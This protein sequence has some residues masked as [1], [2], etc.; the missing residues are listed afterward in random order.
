MTD[1][2]LFACGTSTSWTRNAARAEDFEIAGIL[3]HQRARVEA[4]HA[5][6]RCIVNG[7][8]SFR[9]CG[10]AMR[11]LDTASRRSV[12]RTSLGIV[13][14]IQPTSP[15]PKVGARGSFPAR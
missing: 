8:G 13:G 11:S 15:T 7:P 10:N 5:L 14:A 2:L 9:S 12:S 1:P 3:D 6:D 4:Q